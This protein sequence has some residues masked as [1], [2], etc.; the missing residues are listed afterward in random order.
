MRQLVLLLFLL[1][2]LLLLDLLL[3]LPLLLLMYL[4]AALRFRF[5]LLLLPFDLVLLLLLAPLLGLAQTLLPGLD[6]FL[7]RL[8][9]FTLL[10]FLTPQF[11][12]LLRS[13]LILAGLTPPIL[14]LLLHSLPLRLLRLPSLH[15]LLVLWSV[16]A[17]AGVRFQAALFLPLFLSLPR[18]LRQVAAVFLFALGKRQRLVRS[19]LRSLE[20]RFLKPLGDGTGGLVA[21]AEVPP[22]CFKFLDRVNSRPVRQIAVSGEMVLHF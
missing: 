7:V 14:L 10:L 15:L 17:A 12:L 16:G 18:A 4:L 6:L 3:L 21:V 1:P 19:G 8:F 22:P 13:R 5:L 20:A 2:L 11:R 9:L